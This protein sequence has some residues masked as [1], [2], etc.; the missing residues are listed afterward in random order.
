VPFIGEYGAIDHP[1]VPLAEREKYYRTIT[2]AYASI[3]V[4][5]CAWAYTNTFKLRQ[6]NQWLRGMVEALQTTTTL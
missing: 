3:G 1:K 6:G 5:S 4:Q 2:A